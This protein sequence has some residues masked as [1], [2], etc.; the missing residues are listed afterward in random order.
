MGVQHVRL[1]HGPVQFE[2]LRSSERSFGR[3]LQ[4][5]RGKIGGGRAQKQRVVVVADLVEFVGREGALRR[6]RGR[7]GEIVVRVGRKGSDERLRREPSDD[8]PAENADDEGIA[9]KMTSG[10]GGGR[11]WIYSETSQLF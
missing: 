6:R 4:S 9:V 10:G 8:L 2:A 5:P 7:A 1:R 3:G 11:R